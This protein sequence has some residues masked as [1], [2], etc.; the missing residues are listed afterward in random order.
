M[1]KKRSPEI[2]VAV[3][4]TL[5]GKYRVERI[6]G[7]GGMGVVVAAEHLQL[8]E[9]VALKFLLP[10]ALSHTDVVARFER[11]GQLA[12]KVRSEHAARVYDVGT[13]ENGAPF[14][15]MEYLEGRDLAAVIDER[16]VVPLRDAALYL[17][18]ICD[19]LAEAHSL[20]IVHRDL[21][22]GNLILTRKRDGSP[23]VKLIDFG[24][25]KLMTPG[26][27][28]SMTLPAMMMGSPLYMAPEQMTSARD[29]DHRTDIWSLG[30]IFFQLLTGKPPFDAK[31]V[32]D[33][34][35]LIQRGPPKIRDNRPE[36][37][38]GVEKII[39]RCL[40]KDPEERYANV[41][42]LAADLVPLGP[43]QAGHM[44][45][46]IR[47]VLG[48]AA[49]THPPP[50]P[51]DAE[52]ES[53]E[54]IP[55]VDPARSALPGASAPKAAPS[56]TRTPVVPISARELTPIPFLSPP[57][58]T[59]APRAMA[60]HPHPSERP[61]A[62]ARPDTEARAPSAPDLPAQEE[63]P[64]PLRKAPPASMT[65]TGITAE[66]AIREAL[67][68]HGLD[69]KVLVKGNQVELYGKGS[70][71]LIE[72]GPLGEQWPLIPPDMRRRKAADVARRLA[73]AHRMVIAASGGSKGG[74]SPETSA[75][76]VRI[77]AGAVLLVA[78]VAL[79]QLWRRANAPGPPP[80]PVHTET[81]DEE[82]QRLATTCNAM[83]QRIYSGASVGPYE[84]GGWA[85]ELWLANRS[86]PV[87]REAKA[88]TAAVRDGKLD[89]VADEVLGKITDGTLAVEDE[90]AALPPT[91]RSPAYRTV[92]LVFG[93]G[94]SRA[95]FDPDARPRFLGLADRLADGAGAELASLH[96]RCAG[97]QIRDVGAWF[98]GRDP[99]GAAAALLLGVGIYA[100]RPAVDR[101]ALARFPGPGEVASVHEAALASK[102]DLA[103]LKSLVGDDGGAVT[104]TPSAVTVTFSVGGPIRATSAS[105]TV[106]KK[107]G[108][109]RS[110]IPTSP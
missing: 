87:P 15:V 39:D 18:Q 4:D 63:P 61:E 9:R 62:E 31:S 52:L 104:V 51:P 107:L 58:A 6:L 44:A 109:A 43:S 23:A 105:R 68:G 73:E 110:E 97:S 46:S 83:R 106:A 77:G 74:L 93:G 49:V 86:G 10:E 13:L 84:A 54:I 66:E 67:G 37:S 42:E 91:A 71:I 33:V 90:T 19:A 79:V 82:R 28:R 72:V 76:L 47:R 92:T 95:F 59:P 88:I 108:I 55:S 8:G 102:L 36:L 34:Y 14:I 99:A 24:I 38:A 81:P 41:A 50:A 98:R 75:L 29:V 27:D 60:V 56:A 26:V 3:G 20:G 100:E 65:D 12:A 103:T 5:A 80:P 96:A 22:P 89:P 64:E 35:D 70:P 16:K 1:S 21:K 48:S 45:E 2:P 69:G 30:A 17:L 11:E 101:D 53:I 94:Y 40:R 25:S 57:G 32:S 85:V 7:A 78:A